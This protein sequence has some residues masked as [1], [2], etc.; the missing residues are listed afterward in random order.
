MGFFDKKYCDVCGAKIGLLGNRKLD[1]GNLCKDCAAKL[2][3]F[4]SDRRR[5]TIEQIRE[6]L[7]YRE[8]NQEAVRNFN[9]TRT[10]GHNWKV[11][12]D[13][14]AGKFMVTRARKLAEAN[15]DVIDLSAVTGCQIDIDEHKS[16]EKHKDKDGNYVSYIPARYDYSYDFDIII[17][18]NH[19][20]FDEI[21]F[22]LNDSSVKTG[23]RSINAT[24]PTPGMRPFGA[25]K[26]GAAVS[27]A[28][29]LGAALGSALNAASGGAGSNE[30]WNVEYRQYLH[31][32]EEIRDTLLQTRNEI[33][34]EKEAAGAFR[35]K[36]V[37]PACGATTTPDANG[38]CEYCGCSVV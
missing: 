1:D 16:E 15:P 24:V 32:A 28:S 19:P 22:Q 27:A 21:R 11:L 38:C 34:E 2:S 31:E 14:D 36:V 17:N 30:P 13:E 8:E 25:G 18:V 33:R 23:N 20:Y 6:Q 35:A 9:V 4:F 10:F 37:C 7:A 29:I 12:I 3:P 5:S 26:Q